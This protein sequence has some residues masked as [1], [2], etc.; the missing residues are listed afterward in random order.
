MGNATPLCVRSDENEVASGD[1]S[2][3]P[4][5]SENVM[6]R[7]SEPAS[8]ESESVSESEDDI[9]EDGTSR[10]SSNSTEGVNENQH[11]ERSVA[12]ALLFNI[13]PLEVVE[14]EGKD[15]LAEVGLQ[16]ENRYK[17]QLSLQYYYLYLDR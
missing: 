7:N 3:E 12:A 11:S 5:G 16:K 13:L 2:I 6:R 17:T 8:D 9:S 1:Q 4:D 10:R 15:I 14:A